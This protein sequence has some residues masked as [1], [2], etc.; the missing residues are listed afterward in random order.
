MM[1]PIYQVDPALDVPIYQQLV[2]RVRVS[3]K[4]GLL[5]V[6]QKLPTVQE[7]AET[8]AVA[9]GTIKRAYDELER[10]AWELRQSEGTGHGGYRQPSG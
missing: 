5:K 8:L 7:M 9:R 10:E 1:E 2:D 4:K 3:I 6:G